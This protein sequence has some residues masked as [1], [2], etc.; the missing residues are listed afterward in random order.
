MTITLNYL[1]LVK[2]LEK[3]NIVIQEK[4]LSING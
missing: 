3:K 4:D 1:L 2:T